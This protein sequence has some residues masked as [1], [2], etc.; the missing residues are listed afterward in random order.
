MHPRASVILFAFLPF[1]LGVAA[2]S[3]SFAQ[4][5]AV[6][7]APGI[8][9]QLQPTFDRLETRA[10][11]WLQKS[12]LLGLALL[13]LGF[14]AF[15]AK[16]FARLEFPYRF[17]DGPLLQDIGRRIV[18]TLTMIVG[19]VFVLELLELTYLLGAI[20]GAAGVLGIVLGF[21][22]KEIIENYLASLLLGIRRPFASKDHVAINDHEGLVIRLT[23]RDT[24]LMTLEG[25]HLRLPNSVVFKAEI[26]NYTRNPMRRFDFTV[27]LGVE[28]DM[29]AAIRLGC[30]TLSNTDGVSHDEP[31]FARVEALADSN[32]ALRFFAWV[33]Q[34]NADWYKVRS[35]AIRRVKVALDAAGIDMPVPIYRVQLERP[36]P[37]ERQGQIASLRASDTPAHAVHVDGYLQDQ[38]DRE[39]RTET[40]PNLLDD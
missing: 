31:P 26:L 36:S 11:G 5:V 18:S 20:F 16:V 3:L 27:G 29:S 34:G 32:V 7:T 39:Q 2:P 25:N 1:C 17:L 8:V 13:T 10:I 9:E 14:F 24:I 28:E 6:D 38:I 23:S 40:E 33:D 37:A 12:P 35:E 21:A 19:V 15:L 22:F 4:G 30:Q